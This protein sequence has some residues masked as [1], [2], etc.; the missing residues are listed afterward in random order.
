ML[1]RLRFAIGLFC[2]AIVA[3]AQSGISGN[4]A[5][6][7]NGLPAVLLT[8]NESGARVGGT[9]TFYFQQ[10]G[11]DGKWHLGE[12]YTGPLL[13]PEMRGKLLYF[14]VAHHTEHGGAEPGPNKKY[15]VEFTGEDEARM[16]EVTSPDRPGTGLPLTR[17]SR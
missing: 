16:R 14:E 9:I 11:A 6:T 15:Y 3:A 12:P 4:W 7:V 13:V 10:K 8:L 1:A 2:L 17:T 5:G